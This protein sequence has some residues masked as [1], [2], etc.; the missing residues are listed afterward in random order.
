MFRHRTARAAL[1]LVVAAVLGVVALP[2]TAAAAPTLRGGWAPLN[3]CPVDDPAMLAATGTTSVASCVAAD[4][5]GGSITLGGTTLVTGA[6]N[7]Q[8]GL[9]N[10]GGVFTV[11][12]PAGGA[13]IS[14]PVQIP[15]G[16]LGLMCPS[17][18][19]FVSQ[20]CNLIAG[21]GANVITAT[22]VPAGTPSEFS[23]PAGLG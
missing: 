18:I 11:I 17:N 15:G 21:G 13:I 14:A 12:P 22:V 2:G 1:A 8:F 9:V 4:S 19:P 3:R 5:A 20:I 16:L 7:L 10:T 6:T 23:L